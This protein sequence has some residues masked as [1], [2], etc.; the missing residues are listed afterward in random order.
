MG[1]KKKVETKMFKKKK[2]VITMEV[3][4]EMIEKHEAGMRVSDIAKLYSKSTS[5]ICT[6]LKKKEE[7]K[8]LDA[9]KGVTRV[10]KQRPRVLEDVEKLLLVWINK[11]QLAGD[12]VNENLICRKAKALY[13]ELVS[14]LPSTSRESEESFK[15]SRG[16]FDNFK[17]RSGIHSVLRRG[18]AA[19]S[20]AEA[21]T[22]Q[23][24]ELIRSEC[25][26][27]QQVFNCNETRL[28]WKKMP[29]RTYITEEES[30]MPGPKP[31]KDRLTL[32]LC[33]NAS[34]ELKVKPL[35]VYHSENPRA[36]KKCKV[37]KSQL[38]V[39]WRSSS[40]PWVT[41]ILFVEWM[42]MVFGPEVKKYLLERN[43]PLKV[44]LVMD[45]SP[46]HPPGLEDDLL[47]EFKF[48]KVKFL[49]PNNTP[50]LQ[51]MDQHVI[52]NFKKLY[53]KALFQQ[54]FEVTEGT[55]LSLRDF[56]K[57]QF[58]IVNCLKLI[59][60]AWNGVTNRTITSAW[61]KLWSDSFVGH[62]IEGCAEFE[63]IVDEIVFLGKAMGLE[64]NEDDIE[65]LVE[66]HG[67]ELTT[68]ELM[69]LHCE[70]QKEVMEVILTG[71]EE[72]RSEDS[73]TANEIQEEHGQE[74][75]TEEL[76]DLHC[77]QQ[78]EV[79]EVILTGKEEER[80]EDSLTANEI[81]EMCKMWE[82]LQNF[83]EK[84]HPNKVV[85]VRAMNL[86]NDHAMSHFRG[87]LKK[88][89]KSL[90]RFLIKSSPKRKKQFGE[91]TQ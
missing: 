27:Q 49:P 37:Q 61:A 1:P 54:C 11:K 69:D 25:Y 41:R 47:E 4:K 44:L 86:F 52:S 78:K 53:T 26:L 20:D 12:T 6:I 59:D 45:N 48:I 40:K 21:F 14:K 5:T 71:K 18:E 42:N 22:A 89:Q 43:L 79:M 51:P 74:L 65:E 28:F 34:G 90:D 55:N 19:S 83:V 73:L 72:E 82:T 57:N 32:L 2:E 3:K 31:M 38:N 80:S 87:I 66:E 50:L 84:H 81:Q 16:W 33:T 58:N 29:R 63:P 67:Q 91:S 35:L 30:A 23:F 76:M 17:R 64:V 24:Q 10:S 62:D 56:W 15:A 46:A 85:A 7:I 13:T 75:T 68:E 60:K 70:Q 9:A 77:E 88:R 39:M 36:F 8:G